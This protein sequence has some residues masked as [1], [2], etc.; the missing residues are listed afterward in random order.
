VST[1]E[2]ARFSAGLQGN[3]RGKESV[4]LSSLSE[5]HYPDSPFH[6]ARMKA[7]HLSSNT[8]MQSQRFIIHMV[9]RLN[10]GFSRCLILLMVCHYIILLFQWR[11][12]NTQSF[13]STLSSDTFHLPVSTGLS[14]L[15]R[16][17]QMAVACPAISVV[18]HCEFSFS[19]LRSYT[20][21]SCTRAA[22]VR[23]TPY[24]C[25]PST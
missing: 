20:T 4:S 5:S 14:G 25:R 10:M 21:V 23:F 3:L 11:D 18:R 9:G 17:T 8:N 22:S 19:L 12:I 15:V 1:G 13:V 24:C 2:F 16:T 7:T 6:N